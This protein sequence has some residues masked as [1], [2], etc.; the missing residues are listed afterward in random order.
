MCDS[1]AANN[2][3]PITPKICSK[4]IESQSA[5]AGTKFLTFKL[6]GIMFGCSRFCFST[7]EDSAMETFMKSEG[8][9]KYMEADLYIPGNILFVDGNSLKTTDG[10]RTTIITGNVSTSGYVEGTASEALYNSITSFT[11]IS[12]TLVVIADNGNDCLRLLDRTTANSSQYVGYCYPG[13]GMGGPMSY[14]LAITQNLKSPDMI[15][16][17]DDYAIHQVNSSNNPPDVSQAFDVNAFYL[18]QDPQTGDLYTTTDTRVN[19]ISNSSGTAVKLS[20]SFNG[21][22]D[23]D[24]DFARFETL[25]G[26]IFLHDKILVAD[27]GNNRLRVLD[28]NTNQTSSICSG[29]RGHKDGNLSICSLAEPYSLMLHEGEIYVGE[30]RRIRKIK[31]L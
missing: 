1:K 23:G 7:F 30:N 27:E 24:F 21:H 18:T 4:I 16:V 26:I 20:G 22:R 17:T 29:E 9:V 15:F 3:S 8:Q 19:K 31:G 28:L 5:S 11:Q 6:I 10:T 25:Q 12:P 13:G 14:P 2:S